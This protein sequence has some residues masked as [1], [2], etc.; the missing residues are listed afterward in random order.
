M[1]REAEIEQAICSEAED[2]GWLQRKLMFIGTRGANDRI[3]GKAGR[4]VLIEFKRPGETPSRQQAKRHR[5]LREDFGLEVHWCDNMD[6]ARRI[7][8]LEVW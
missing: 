8:N 1:A 6:D 5:E 2:A 3:F 4:A 7:L